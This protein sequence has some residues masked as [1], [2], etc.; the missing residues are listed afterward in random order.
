MHSINIKIIRDLGMFLLTFLSA[1]RYRVQKDLCV[2]ACVRACVRYEKHVIYFPVGLSTC[3]RQ[4]L[5]SVFGHSLTCGQLR[6]S[7]NILFVPLVPC[8][9]SFTITVI[10][11]TCI[12]ISETDT[13][14]PCIH[15][16]FRNSKTRVIWLST[17]G[18]SVISCNKKAYCYGR[19]YMFLPTLKCTSSLAVKWNA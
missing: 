18:W 4:R 9:L 2:R 8:T 15:M 1:L 10:Y 7:S 13:K 14:R 12:V 19:R 6:R 3:D 5:V 17:C 11:R 16:C